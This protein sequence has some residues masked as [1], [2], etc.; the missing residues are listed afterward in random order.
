MHLRELNYQPKGKKNRIYGIQVKLKWRKLFSTGFYRPPPL[1]CP[2][3]DTFCFTPCSRTVNKL[4][5]AGDAIMSLMTWNTVTTFNS[6]K[7]YY[8]TWSNSMGKIPVACLRCQPLEMAEAEAWDLVK[9]S[10]SPCACDTVGRECND[11]HLRKLK[12][13]IWKHSRN[14][15]TRQKS[16]F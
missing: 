5:C 4:S 12:I 16:T 10:R 8:L 13:R 9:L 15:S 1:C 7:I 2:R 6:M 11:L 3:W 14:I